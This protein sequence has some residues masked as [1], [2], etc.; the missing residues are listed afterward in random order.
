MLKTLLTPALSIFLFTAC[1]DFGS[2]SA[3]GDFG[4]TPGGVKDLRHARDLVANGKVPPA[5]AILPE[6][7]FAEHDLPLEGAPCDQPLC[8][9]A[10]A[11][12]S[13]DLDGN[14]R[15]YAQI[16]L[17]SN[18]DP[19]TWVRPATSYIFTVDVSGSM[20]W[21]HKDIER[22]SAGFLA[23]KALHGLVEQLREDDSVAIVT[24][25]DSAEVAVPLHRVSNKEPLHAAIDKL[26][27]NGSTN[28]EAGVRLALK[29][30]TT[31][32][33]GERRIVLFTDEQPNVGATSPSEFERLLAGAADEGIFSSVLAFGVGIGSEVMRG[34]SAVRG[35][36]AFSMTQ[37]KDVTTFLAD[38]APYFST[39]IAHSLEVTSSCGAPWQIEKG[40]GFP[41]ASDEAKADLRVASVF[42]SKKRGAL[43]VSLRSAEPADVY[44][45][46]SLS[47][48]TPA[49]EVVATQLDANWSRSS[50]DASGRGFAQPS[51]AR[52]TAMALL[53]ET[54]HT[55]LGSYNSD[56]ATSEALL[57]KA[58]TRFAA[59]VQAIGGTELDNEVAF[60]EALLKLVKARAPQ[61]TFY[62]P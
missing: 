53:T 47:Y 38:D 21:D 29:T 35:A 15:G 9:R 55:A 33:A 16:G 57:D 34:M 59:D 27:T 30:A 10:A 52:T 20:G 1:S 14:T 22:P 62:G 31:A 50:N 5:D 26:R 40:Y 49:G 2:S 43:L 51:V 58:H 4:A 19:A 54:M 41:K 37:D 23:R 45:Q 28:M 11:G 24:Y 13:P 61:G 46:F 7:M 8:L 32:A 18:I 17:S 25:G 44:S 12:M 36:N 3:S 39:P 6:A 56:P 42:L 60:S 48:R